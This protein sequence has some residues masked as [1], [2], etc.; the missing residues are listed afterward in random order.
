MPDP[1]TIAPVSAPRLSDGAI[2]LNGHEAAD[3]DAQVAGEDDEMARRFGWFPKRS[4]RQDAKQAIERWEREWRTDGST[5]AFAVREAATCTLIGGCELRLGASGTAAMSY[6]IFPSHRR[7]AY[8]ARAVELAC[9]YA[10]GELGVEVIELH[11]E[12]SNEASLGV[13]RRAGFCEDRGPARTGELA[14]DMVLWSR[15][16]TGRGREAAPASYTA[17]S[18]TALV[19][20]VPEVEQVVGRCRWRFDPS[21]AYRGAFD[22]IVPHLTLAD[23]VEGPEMERIRGQVGPVLPL[24]TVL[25]EVRLAAFGAGHWSFVAS[26]PL[27]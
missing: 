8:A 7:R 17:S 2:V 13:A 4:S 25:Y 18:T 22:D 6:W 3:V 23:G 5:R 16:A 24:R 27:N 14:P 15:R 10:F 11:I 9:D 19:L 26:F 1:V 20:P 21:A 12:A